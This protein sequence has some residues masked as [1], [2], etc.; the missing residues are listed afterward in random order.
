MVDMIELL[1]EELPLLHHVGPLHPG[2][3]GEEETGRLSSAVDVNTGE[4]WD[5]GSGE[6]H[7][8]LVLLPFLPSPQ[9]LSDITQASHWSLK[10]AKNLFHVLT[11]IISNVNPKQIA[12]QWQG[13]PAS[14][15]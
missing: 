6:D 3:P 15:L 14:P 13:Q 11:T 1:H 5:S 7:L 4:D 8:E 10:S 12:V 9:T 2:T